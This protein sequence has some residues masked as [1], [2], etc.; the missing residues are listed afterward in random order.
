MLDEAT[1]TAILK[2]HT[3]GHG[4]GMIARILATG[5]STVRRV[6][7]SGHAGATAGARTTRGSL[8][9]HQAIVPQSQRLQVPR[10]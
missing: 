9:S 7:A 6:I 5:R 8:G 2:L 1:R 10:T 4:S 3:Q